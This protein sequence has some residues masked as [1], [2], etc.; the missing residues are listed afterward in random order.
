[1]ATKPTPFKLHVPDAEIADLHDRLARTRFPDEVV[2]LCVVEQIR[3]LSF[4]PGP[5]AMQIVYPMV[6]PKKSSKTR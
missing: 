6:F 5:E 2:T 3:L 1:M 4:P